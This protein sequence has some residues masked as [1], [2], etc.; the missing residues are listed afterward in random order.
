MNPHNQRFAEQAVELG[1][2][3]GS[4]CSAA[5]RR[6]SQDT[7]RTARNARRLKM[8]EKGRLYRIAD[9]EGG[10]RACEEFCRFQGLPKTE[11]VQ[12]VG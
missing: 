5:K 8:I 9:F 2:K 7:L 11:I 10:R 4:V 6:A 12:V 3:G 1:R